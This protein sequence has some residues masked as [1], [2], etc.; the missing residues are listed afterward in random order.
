MRLAKFYNLIMPK[1]DLS[2]GSGIKL[3]YKLIKSLRETNNKIH[4]PKTYNK[5]IDDLIHKNKWRKV[6]DKEL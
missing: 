4:E 1:T 3:V 2:L 6:I 5:A